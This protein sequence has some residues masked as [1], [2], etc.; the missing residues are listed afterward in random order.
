[1]TLWFDV[2][3]VAIVINLVLL[4]GLGYVWGRNYAKFRS[5]HTLGLLLFSAILLVENG[6]ALY[7]YT[8][9]PVL[10]VWIAQVPPPAQRAM[11]LLRVSE[12]AAL[13]VLTWA[14]WD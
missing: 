2:A 4:L 9:D 7:I 6:F 13:G 8:L 12:A 1:M 10:S 11:T 3:R 14:T 5:K